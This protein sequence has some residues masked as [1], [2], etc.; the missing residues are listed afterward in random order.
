MTQTVLKAPFPAFGGKSH[1]IEPFA[2][3]AAMLLRRPGGPGS[4]ETINDLNAYVANF[5]RAVQHD[6]EAVAAHADWPVNETDL[7]ARHRWLVRSDRAKHIL[8][9]VKDDPAAYDVRMAGWWC[10]GACLWI[11]AGWCDTQAQK[12]PHISD[13]TQKRPHLDPTRG[14]IGERPDAEAKIWEGRG[15]AF[16]GD[17]QFG[18]GRGV[19]ARTSGDL[20]RPQLCNGNTTAGPGVL[21]HPSDIG[22]KPSGL[23]H[24]PQLADEFS[25]GRGVNGNDRAGTCEARRAWLTDWMMRL[26]DRMRPVRVS[27]GHWDRVCDSDSTTVRLGETGVFLDPPYRKELACGKK[28]RASHIYANDRV[29][30]VNKLCDQVQ[31]WCLKW[32]SNPL[33][34]IALCGLEGEYPAIDEAGWTKVEWKSRGYGNRTER[35]KENAARERVWFSPNCVTPES[36]F[37][38][39][40]QPREAVSA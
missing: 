20:K 30:D 16:A 1:Y 37:D 10:W 13:V 2:F 8:R 22:D 9:S 34:R 25:R 5:W 12:L 35:G 32:G 26:A 31:D 15:S 6:P 39:F 33:M 11:G 28:N 3:S 14:I 19:N 24:R 27:C 29:Q 23:A 40:T 36:S 4:I 18:V 17:G 7:H 21:A 38:L